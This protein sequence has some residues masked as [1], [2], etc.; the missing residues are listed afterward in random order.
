MVKH[1]KDP[2]NAMMRSNA[3]KMMDKMTIM[4][5]TKRRIAAREIC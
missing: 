4:A 2:M 3:G 1:R 5:T